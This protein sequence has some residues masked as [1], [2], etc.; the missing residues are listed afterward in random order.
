MIQDNPERKNIPYME[1]LSNLLNGGKFAGIRMENVMRSTGKRE[2]KQPKKRLRDL[3]RKHFKKGGGEQSKWIKNIYAAKRKFYIE[4]LD[5]FM[6]YKSYNMKKDD[7][8]IEADIVME[9]LEN[10]D[11]TNIVYLRAR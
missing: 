2:K 6:N 7:A 3:I 4:I 5:S 10:I 9:M 1:L 11:K 8:F